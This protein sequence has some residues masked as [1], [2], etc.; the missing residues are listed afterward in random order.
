MNNIVTLKKVTVG[1][2]IDSNQQ[3]TLRFSWDATNVVFNT[4]IGRIFMWVND[5][6]AQHEF[7]LPH[8]A[9]VTDVI[10]PDRVKGQWSLLF[11]APITEAR[12]F[13][14]FMAGRWNFLI[15]EYH[16]RAVH[17]R[18][19]TPKESGGLYLAI[20]N[21]CI[22]YNKTPEEIMDDASMIGD[23]V[24]ELNKEGFSKDHA[25]EILRV[26]GYRYVP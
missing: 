25:H 19:L 17:H 3:S 9:G 13:A 4:E 16:S 22:A 24:H 12:N 6:L 20:G 14:W 23:L 21:N 10:A 26:A 18:E 7:Q 15:T 2:Y 11:N 5:L 8:Q 1:L